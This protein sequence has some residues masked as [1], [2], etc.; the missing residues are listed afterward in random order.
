MNNIQCKKNWA[1]RLPFLL[2]IQISLMSI[3]VFY[4]CKTIFS[5]E[6][7]VIN[8]VLGNID[9]SYLFILTV[10]SAILYVQFNAKKANLL[11]FGIYPLIFT[12]LSLIN[13][14]SIK[15]PGI[16]FLSLCLTTT[17]LLWLIEVLLCKFSKFIVFIITPLN[18]ILSIFLAIDTVYYSLASNHINRVH[19][20]LIRS[21]GD[22]QVGHLLKIGVP[23]LAVLLFILIFV[24]LLASI[25]PILKY[26]VTIS[27]SKKYVYLLPFSTMALIISLYVLFPSISHTMTSSEYFNFR[28]RNSWFPTPPKKILKSKTISEVEKFV[29]S[30]KIPLADFNKQ[31]NYKLTQAKLDTN[32]VFLFFESLRADAVDSLMPKT[33]AIARNG[34]RCLNHFSNSNDTEGGMISTYYG[35]LPISLQRPYYDNHP[36]SWLE[37]MKKNGYKFIRFHNTMGSLYYPGYKYTSYKKYLKSA[38][39]KCK[40]NTS[41]AENSLFIFNSIIEQLKSGN[42]NIIE[43]YLFHTHYNYHYPPEFEVFKPVLKSNSEILTSE[44]NVVAQKLQ[45]QYKNSILYSDYLVSYFFHKLE[46]NNLLDNTIVVLIGDHGECLGENGKLFHASGPQEKQYRTPLIIFGK[47][48]PHKVISKITSHIDIIPTLGEILGFKA[49]NTYGHSVLDS[50]TYGAITFDIDCTTR[51]IYRRKK[52]SSIFDISYNNKLKWQLTT[53]SNFAFGSKF[54]KE[55]SPVNI[56]SLSSEIKSDAI[57]LI[58]IIKKER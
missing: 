46:Q 23:P 43:G 14:I 30:N 34:I 53:N 19:F 7:S 5:L 29:E 36:S 1:N 50:K 42:K 58:K 26:G 37:F 12:A 28:L 20:R 27:P 41:I 22:N 56:A 49:N 10:V 33:K 52:R 24:S 40:E 39:I 8:S 48:V 54:D 55:Y 18:I 16:W 6:F 17:Y 9:V 47:N 13:M 2:L 4:F 44:F 35:T 15:S 32:I 3:I 25:Y 51:C 38:G 57:N 11:V 45:N 31:P 21:V